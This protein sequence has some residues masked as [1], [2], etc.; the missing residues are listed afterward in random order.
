[1]TVTVA[2]RADVVW[3]GATTIVMV[4]VSLP[5]AGP[6]KVTQLAFD[7]AAHVQLPDVFVIATANVPPPA[8]GDCDVDASVYAQVV[9][10]VGV[11]FLLLQPETAAAATS[12]T[13]TK[14]SFMI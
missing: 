8:G 6:E 4:A 7:E 9:G 10:C 13:V 2:A 1:M 12:A 3:F 11:V 14:K 5:D